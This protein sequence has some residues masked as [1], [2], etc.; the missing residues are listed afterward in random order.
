MPTDLTFNLSTFQ[1]YQETNMAE[2][3]PTLDQWRTLYDLA[4]QIKELAPWEWMEEVDI[5]GVQ[6]PQTQEIGY[7][8]VMGQLGE[9]V[10]VAVY[11]GSRGID[12]F[13]KMQDAAD[14]GAMP[15]PEMVLET[16]QLQLSFED[17]EMIEKEDREIY[18]Q[19]GLKFRGPQSW[20]CFRTYRPG[21]VPWMINAEEADLLTVAL[22]QLFEVAPRYRDDEALL[23]PEDEDLYL[24]RKA[25]NENGVLIWKDHY[26]NI[27]MPPPYET[28]F[29]VPGA[30]VH[31]L[32]KARRVSNVI[33]VDFFLMPSQIRERGKRPFFPYNM[34]MVESQS[35]MILATEMFDP[36]AGLEAMW[37]EL[38]VKFLEVLAHQGVCPKTIHVQSE[39]LTWVLSPLCEKFD[40]QIK[41]VKSL[42]AMK[43]VRKELD[44]F[45]M[46]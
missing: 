17:R 15:N 38:G 34:L 35:G 41:R 27:P 3:S 32:E 1:P 43:Q 19:L 6:H 13:F 45:L 25:V 12:G 28:H 5:F 31:A 2:T 8:S 7:L 10:A 18:K 36:T 16:P 24:I 9:H 39:L 46:R 40:I 22:Q 29:S 14:E 33:E 4:A 44:R 30:V 37:N 26:E 23:Y 21:M 42:K 20:P 11:R